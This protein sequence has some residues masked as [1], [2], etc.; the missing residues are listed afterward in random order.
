MFHPFGSPF[1]ENQV[2][3]GRKAID[4]PKLNGMMH[5]ECGFEAVERVTGRHFGG[6]AAKDHS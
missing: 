5:R 6:G 1:A 3:I 2:N 4:G